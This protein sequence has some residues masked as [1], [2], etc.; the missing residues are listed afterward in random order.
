MSVATVEAIVLLAVD[1]HIIAHRFVLK[2]L[3]L[4]AHILSPDSLWKFTPSKISSLNDPDGVEF[5]Y[6]RAVVVPL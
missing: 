3:S 5:A 4:I 1:K 2:R 6:D